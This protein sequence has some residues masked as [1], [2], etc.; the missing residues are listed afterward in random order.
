MLIFATPGISSPL[1]PQGKELGF[2]PQPARSAT[3]EYCLL[4]RAF[5]GETFFL[6]GGGGRFFFSSPVY[7]F[8]LVLA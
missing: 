7:Q 3:R 2:N 8:L 1:L 5:V 4:F 6:E